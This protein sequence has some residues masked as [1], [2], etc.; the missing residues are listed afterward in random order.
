MT[1]LLEWD[2]DSSVE[3]I[4]LFIEVFEDNPWGFAVT[5]IYGSGGLRERISSRV[6]SS[7]GLNWTSNVTNYH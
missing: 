2:G 5:H 4:D 7:G 6:I 3:V 1:K